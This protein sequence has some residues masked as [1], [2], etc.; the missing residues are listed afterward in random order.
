MALAYT[1]F[2]NA[3]LYLEWAPDNAFKAATTAASVEK[4]EEDEKVE[5][6]EVA[7]DEEPGKTISSFDDSQSY[8]GKMKLFSGI[9][10]V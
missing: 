4:K 6:E 3:P 7:E 10:I 2:K 5:V 9:L 8:V 1:K